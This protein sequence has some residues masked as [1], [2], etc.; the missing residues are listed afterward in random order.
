MLAKTNQKAA[1]VVAVIAIVYLLLSFNLPGYSNALIDADVIPKGL[2]FLLLF[3]ALLLYLD[4][5]NETEADK[6][7]RKISKQHVINLLVVA[8]MILIYIFLLEMIGFVVMT[9]VFIFVCSLYLDYKHHVT[10]VI[11]SVVFSLAIYGLFNYLL[12]INLPAGIL[13]F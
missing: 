13:P 1:L 11:T 12:K 6:E 9:T 8:G 7:K 5:K 4:K 2:G 3:F 10:N